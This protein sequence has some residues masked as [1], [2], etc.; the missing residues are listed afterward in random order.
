MNLVYHSGMLWLAA[1][2]ILIVSLISLVGLFTISLNVIRLRKVLFAL[3]SL[4]VGALLGDV[5]LHILPELEVTPKITSLIF[6]GFLIFFVLEK[7]LRWHHG[8]EG[9]VH[10]VGVEID[11]GHANQH[12]GYM[13]IISD[14][15]HNL[16]DGIVIGGAYLVSTEVGIATTIAVILHE[17]PQEIGDFGLLLHVG[18]SR[19]RALFLNFLSALASFAGLL[20]VVAL[21]GN[22]EGL[23]ELILPI[24]AGGFLY[25]AASDLVPELQKTSSARKSLIQL[26]AIITGFALMAILLALE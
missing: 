23:I 14:G 26:I 3:I 1:L 11:S 21:K 6:V 19:A 16:I 13:N 8:H 18:F 9:E 7:F 17:I 2:S 24:T 5:F 22:S 25:I 4:S 15:L 20:I 10:E 12:I